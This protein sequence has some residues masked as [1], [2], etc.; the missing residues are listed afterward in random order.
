MS[1]IKQHGWV[2][3]LCCLLVTL[4]CAGNKNGS[5]GKNGGG[6]PG[7]PPETPQNF[8][9]MALDGQVRLSWNTEPDV[10]YELYH[11]TTAGFAL[12]SGMRISPVTSPYDHEE[13]MNG[14]TYYY[15]LRA[16]NDFGA[17]EPTAEISA[18]PG[19][20]PETPQNFTA[21]ALDE[22]VR[23]SWNTEPDVTYELYHS[24][25]TGFALENG[26]RIS[27]VTSP[28]DHEELMNGTTYY[29]RLRAVNDFGASEPTGE[30]SATPGSPPETP[31]NFTAMALD[32]Q[33]RL[34]WNT[35]PDV[36]YELYHSTT[37]GFT[38]ESG[39]RISP[40]TTPYDH[41]ELMNDTTY[42]YRLRAVNDF[43]VSEPT[44]EISATP[45][46]PPETPQN[47][48]A[49]ALDEQVR[50]SWNTEPDV[51]YELYHSTTPG[52]TLENGMK[53]SQVTSPYDHEELMNDT[54]YYYRLRAVNDFGV[55]EPTDEISATPKPPPATPQG[56]MAEASG[57]GQIILSWN[58][59][60]NITYDLYHSTTQGFELANG[61]KIS[62]VTSP[63]PHTELTPNTTYY[64]R[65]TAVNDSGASAPTTEVSKR[66]LPAKPQNFM[67]TVSGRDVRL[68]WED[69]QI[70]VTYTV[71]FG[72]APGIDVG[73]ENPS[74]IEGIPSLFHGFTGLMNNTRH[75]YR[76]TAVNDSG[77]S[78]PTAEVSVIIPPAAP[79]NFM[80]EASGGQVTLSWT[81]LSSLTYDIFFSTSAGID[82]ADTSVMKITG[83]R[84]QPYTHTG[85]TNTTTYYYR[86]RAVN[87][88][89]TGGEPTAEISA[90]PGSPATTPQSFTALASRKQVTLNWTAQASVTYDLFYATTAGIDVGSSTAAK[91]TN[92]TPPYIH[93]ELTDD[94]TYY[95]KLTA[96]NTFGT[97]APTAE[98]SATPRVAEKISAG[99]FHTCAVASGRALCWG[100]NNSG[101]LG[102]G[103][104]SGALTPQQAGDLTT[105]VTQISVGNDHACAVVGGGAFCWG[106]G[107][108]GRLGH[109]EMDS[110]VMN[111]Q[112]ADKLTPTQV[113][114]LTSG[115]TQIS[116][117]GSHT[118]AVVN[119]RAMCWGFGGSGI[120]GAGNRSHSNAPQQVSGLTTEVTQISAGGSHTCAVVN[121]RAMCW[122]FG[123]SGRLGTGSQD[124]QT[125]PQ[126]V[127][128]LTTEVT[129]ISAG[130]T[131]TC[132]V[133]NGAAWC[134]GKGGK[135]QLG[136]NEMGSETGNKLTPTPV[137]GLTSGV[138]HISAG[139]EHTCAVVGGAAKCWGEGDHGRLGTGNNSD[140]TTPTQVVGLTSGVTEISAGKRHTCAVVE[141][142]ALCWGESADGRLGNNNSRD[143][144]NTPVSVNGL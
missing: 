72:S 75:Y 2:F 37:P 76:L 131:H 78:A 134:W 6:D 86:L 124:T 123:G 141:G 23:L 82:V 103:N 59:E 101:Q 121:G 56:L 28:Y 135:L 46:S 142:R 42:Y 133:V 88:S 143:D 81:K 71:F 110:E 140:Q 21:M 20:P 129:Q 58:T 8:E 109:N 115:V 33:V 3:A 104:R 87:D 68:S 83:I 52:F 62:G 31:Q 139:S 112:T 126:Q 122:G 48:T 118:C 1:N 93:T 44:A 106:K 137:D 38:L 105:G 70:G 47:F 64:Y 24:T 5:G 95:Y 138:T 26:M 19:S 91:F 43:G 84:T 97:S 73:N 9:A 61:M 94:T 136:H 55:S 116:A 102:T 17:S 18:T 74:K 114:G 39:M 10:T 51:T 11:S 4:S 32:E 96:R 90:T 63:Y 49:M 53:I 36:T 119:G 127:S 16:V 125:S 111:S 69:S 50:L 67:A 117:G 30:I 89:G 35:E 77:S 34:S 128:G 41:E 132:A 99:N 45:G 80:A 27:P 54:T 130:N 12:E 13:L 120:L 92:V 100:Q 29:Y 66:T 79:E 60:S 22:Q 98:V 85:L 25:E 14:T 57:A 15:R 65:L 40:V 144:Q 7:N 113:D 108:S 107:A